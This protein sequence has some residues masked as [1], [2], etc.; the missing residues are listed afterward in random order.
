MSR[1]RSCNA[2]VV[3]VETE[4]TD[5]KPGRKMPLD[6][7]PSDPRR[8]ARVENGNIIYTG[9]HTGD[10]TPIVRYVTGGPHLSHFASCPNA[11]THRKRK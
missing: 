3:W 11:Q 1:C 9:A 5:T 6:A 4:A 2:A 8:A 10:G 7:N